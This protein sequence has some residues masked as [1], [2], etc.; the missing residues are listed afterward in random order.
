MLQR[1][2]LVGALALAACGA[3]RFV[4]VRDPASRPPPVEILQIALEWSNVFL[5]RE[6]DAAILVDS[7]S[8]GDW[9]ALEAALRAE[10]IAPSALR[11]VVLT[12]AHADHAGLASR[13]QALGVPIA[14][15]AADVAMASRGRDDPLRAT[16]V[17]GEALRP[18]IDFPYPPFT[19][20]V[21]VVAPL[22]LADRGLPHV[23]IEPMPGHTPGSLVV[24]AGV[25]DVLV[26]DVMLGGLGGALGGATAGEHYYQDDPHRNHCNVVR[27]L[28]RGA[29]RFYV[30]HGGPIDRGSVLSWRGEWRIEAARCR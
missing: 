29:R 30:G 25:S 10:G 15:G 22:E 2:L 9:P 3:P 23:R 21:V 8:P 17:L 4:R 27:L 20:D 1:H 24:F 7:G 26:G 12:H 18:F 13:L 5:V 11:L 19:P 6:G 28:A 14:L 16:S